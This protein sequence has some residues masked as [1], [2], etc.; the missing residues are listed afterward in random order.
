MI[1]SLNTNPKSRFI[2]TPT[3]LSGVFII[4]PKPINDERGYF[5]RYFCADD[6]KEIG[7]SK[8]I[9]QINHSV[10]KGIGS[11][12]GLHFQDYPHG[13]TKIMRCLKGSI[14]D[15]ALDLRENS[16]TFLQYFG[17]VLSEENSRYL[18]IPEGFAHGFQTLREYVEVIYPTT[19]PFT[20]SADRVINPLDPLIN[21]SWL[22][23]IGN[24]SPKD[25]NAPYI[26][27]NFKGIKVSNLLTNTQ[28]GGGG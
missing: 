22:E 13:E 23:K 8:P 2:F 17:I 12:R 20:A 7:L 18:Y 1:E 26:D 19:Y 21:I 24:L 9:V 15:I 4:E 6:F 10:T 14:Y 3:P 25:S 16:P 11:I 28:M 5:E 27:S